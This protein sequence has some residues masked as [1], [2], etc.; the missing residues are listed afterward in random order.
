MPERDSDKAR[1]LF[2]KW[3]AGQVE[4]IAPAVLTAEIASMLW[5]RVTRGL[6]PGDKVLRL[7][8]NFS[9]LGLV[10]T[11]IET[12]AQA[13]LVLSITHR[14]PLYDCLYVALAARERCQLMTADERL[15][16]AFNAI[17]PRV[18]L[19]AHWPLVS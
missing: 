15:F 3:N 14:H 11:P 4:L 7:F 16:R 12:L 8:Q 5:K 6:M 1:S 2:E 9:D 13:A 17:F 18:R 10:L 19:L